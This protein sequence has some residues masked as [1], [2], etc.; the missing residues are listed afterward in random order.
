MIGLTDEFALDRSR[1]ALWQS[2]AKKN[3]IVPEPLD[4]IVARLRLAFEP[5]LNRAAR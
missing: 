1:Q 2:F 4:S 3:G 5:A